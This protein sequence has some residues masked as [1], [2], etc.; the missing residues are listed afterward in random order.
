MLAKVFKPLHFRPQLYFIGHNVAKLSHQLFRT[1]DDRVC[2][3]CA[4]PVRALHLTLLCQQI[5]HVLDF[6]K[7]LIIFLYRLPLQRA[8]S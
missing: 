3:L 4:L 8:F 7:M 6:I 1:L 5:V 2:V